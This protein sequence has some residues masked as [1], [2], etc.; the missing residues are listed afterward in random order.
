[1]VTEV[2]VDNG[3]GSVK[4]PLLFSEGG[5]GLKNRQNHVHVIIECPLGI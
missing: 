4:C 2:H 5:E 3:R 1:M